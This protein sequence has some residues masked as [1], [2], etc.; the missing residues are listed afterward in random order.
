M[1]RFVHVDVEA[2]SELQKMFLAAMRN[3]YLASTRQ[4]VI[5]FIIYACKK[6]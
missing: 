5:T 2:V 4:N 6:A 1:L 3:F